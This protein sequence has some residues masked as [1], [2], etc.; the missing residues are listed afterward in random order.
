MQVI[1]ELL[2]VKALLKVDQF[3]YPTVCRELDLAVF[4]FDFIK[5][6]DQL[7]VFLV[8]DSSTNICLDQQV[9]FR[10]WKLFKK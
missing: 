4:F 6:P 10:I 9:A 8:F 2:T 1:I 3:L 5:D 7:G